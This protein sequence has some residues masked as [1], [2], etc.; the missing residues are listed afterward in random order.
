MKALFVDSS[1]HNAQVALF[2]GPN[3][4]K[5][6]TLTCSLADRDF[7]LEVVQLLGEGGPKVIG[8]ILFCS[9]NSGARPIQG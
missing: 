3:V 7:F 9:W 2:E 5:E 8:P 6:K 4:V 1:T